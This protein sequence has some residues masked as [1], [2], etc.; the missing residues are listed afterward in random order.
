M[1]KL[2]LL[3]KVFIMFIML[4]AF[5]STNV[6]AQQAK[7]DKSQSKHELIKKMIQ[8]K[9]YVF[10]AQYALPATGRSHYLTSQYDVRVTNDTI[11]SDLPFF[12]RAYVA[13]MNPADAGIRFTSTEFDYKVTDKKKG[14]WNITILPKD[15]R[16]VRQMYLSVTQ[17]GNAS[18]Q[19]ISNNRQAMN[20]TGSVTTLDKHH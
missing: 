5:M 1:T 2:K 19:V 18:L 3:Q 17:N 10:R 20:F 14:G 6:I 15:T 11:V 8:S 12:G 7:I 13:T 9:N 16:D 4:G